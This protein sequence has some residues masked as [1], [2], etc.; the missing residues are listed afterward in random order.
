MTYRVNMANSVR[1][2]LRGQE[3]C[4]RSGRLTMY[5]FLDVLRHYGDEARAGCPRLTAG[6]A[7]FHMLWTFDAGPA[8]RSLDIFVDDSE[9]DAGV[10]R[11]VYAELLPDIS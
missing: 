2:Y 7:V 5:G 10:L 3:V 6:S 1:H 4:T 11:V 8:A 9:A